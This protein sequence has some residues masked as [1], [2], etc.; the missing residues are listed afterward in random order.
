M[1]RRPI[2]YNAGGMYLSL[3]FIDMPEP[4]GPREW[5]IERER[6][7]ERERER[8]GTERRRRSTRGR[9]ELEPG[10]GLHVTPTTG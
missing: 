6:T 5:E 4:A 1:A 2:P 8:S 3:M 7:R 9:P 10:W